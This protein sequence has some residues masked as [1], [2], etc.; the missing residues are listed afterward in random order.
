MRTGMGKVAAGVLTA[1]ALMVAVAGCGN[2]TTPDAGS[3]LSG[4]AATGGSTGGVL[5]NGAQYASKYKANGTATVTAGQPLTITLGT[6]D[7]QPNTLTV[8]KGTAVTIKLNN[9]SALSHNFS[10]DPFHVS[11]NVDA[12][13]SATVTF[14]P[15]QTGTFYFYCNVSGHA[16]A[17]MVGKITVQ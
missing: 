8:A 3:S 13:Q 2:I 17:G 9:T 15:D 11:Q 4:S 14:T 6:M 1:F 12:G 7:F 16:A 5:D 10:L